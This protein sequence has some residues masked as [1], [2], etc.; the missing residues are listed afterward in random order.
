MP[1][2]KQLS[3]ALGLLTSDHSPVP[4]EDGWQNYV[5]RVHAAQE[6]LDVED[7]YCVLVQDKWDWKRPQYYSFSFRLD[8]KTNS[9]TSRITLR[10]EDTEDDD[11]VCVVA[12]FLNAAGQEVGIFFANWR[13]LPGRSYSREAPIWLTTDVKEIATV[14]VGTKQCDVR[15]TADAENF[16][17]IRMELKQR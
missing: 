6:C 16:Y 2:L 12:S 17:R 10:N 9:V 7:G 5:W 4:N 15:A 11:Q 1:T 3:I 8:P 14:A 13:A